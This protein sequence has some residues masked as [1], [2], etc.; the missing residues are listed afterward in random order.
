M[1]RTANLLLKGLLVALV[2]IL[3]LLPVHAFVS[4]WGGT[5]IGP[6]LVWK[7]WKEILLVILLPAVIAYL[8]VRPDV[9]VL[10]ARRWVNWLVV[11]YIAVHGVWAVA[12]SA[13][14]EAVLAGLLFNLRFLVMFLLAQA[15]VASGHPWVHKLKQLVGP[16]LLTV[17]VVIATLAVVQVTLLPADFLSQFGYNKDT[18]IAP[19]ILIDQN[20]DALRAFATLRGPNDLGAYLLTPLALAAVLVVADRRNV[21]AGLALGLGLAAL[22]ATGSRS[23]WLGAL[24]MGL[25]LLWLWV[26]KP[27]LIKIMRVSLLPLLMALGLF[28]WLSTTVPA[29][30]LAVFH[31]SP[32][33]PLLEGSTQKHWEATATGVADALAHPWGQGVGTAG[34][35]SFYNHATPKIAENYFVQIGQEVGALGVL[36]FVAICGFVAFHLWQQRRELWPKVLL[37][38]F[39]GLTAI[40][41]LLHGWSDDPMA[42]TWWALAG[43]YAFNVKKAKP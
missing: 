9:A 34:P 14:Q 31:S 36:L 1:E 6:L 10:L 15:I 33:E 22:V 11:A 38:S 3:A 37:A 17:T 41:L 26:P 35:A 4:T 23:A 43:L 12:S 28:L 7:A 18:T 20:P 29:L 8:V 2:V 21:L 19:Y 25:V 5:A 39:V 16:L 30:R 27:Q 24:C 32:G 40:N 42:M 13:S